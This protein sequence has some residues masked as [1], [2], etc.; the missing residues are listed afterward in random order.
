MSHGYRAV[1]RHHPRVKRRAAHYQHALI[2]RHARGLPPHLLPGITG[3]TKRPTR[4]RMALLAGT[5][6]F[7]ITLIVGVIGTVVSSVAAVGGTLHAYREV[8]EGLPNAAAIATDAYE[9]AEIYDRN[10]VL[11]QQVSHPDQGWRTFVALDQV[12]EVAIDAT[13][14]AED[15]TFWSHYGIEPLAILRGALIIAGGEGTSGGST[16]TQQL[17]RGLYPER[18]G[19]DISLTRKFKEILGAVAIDKEY[20]KQ[21]I[22]SMYL[23]LIYYGQRS[24]G[25]E[26]AAQTYFAKSAKELNLAEASMLA[27][28]PQ[29]PSFYDPTVRYDE[30]KVRQR[31]VLD[32]MVKYRYITRAEAEEA[33]AVLLHPQRRNTAIQHAPHFTN[34]VKSYLA[35]TYGEDALYRGGLRIYTT[36]DVELQDRAQRLVSEHVAAMAPYNAHNGAMVV[37]VPWSGEIL[38]MVGSANFDDPLIDGQVNVALAERQPG[39]SIKPITYAAAFEL[40]WNPN[41]VIVDERVRIPTPGAPDPFYEPQNYTS[42]FYGRMTV[43]TALSNSLNIPAVK[44]MQRVGVDRF[45]DLAERMGIKDGLKDRQNYGLALTLGGGEVQLLELTNVYG[46]FANNGRYVPGTPILRIED[47]QGNVIYELDRERVYDEAEQALDADYAYMISSILSDNEARGMIFGRGNLFEQTSEQI[48]RPTTA[49]S[50]TTNDFKDNWTMGYTT[51]AVVGVW[52]GNSDGSPLAQIDGIQGA[53]P[54]WSRMLFELHQNPRFAELLLG[55]NGRPLPEEFQRP[56]GLR[57]AELFCGERGQPSCNTGRGSD[58]N[59]GPGQ[60]GPPENSFDDE[61]E[62]QRIQPVGG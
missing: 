50:G 24:F 37:M 55:P 23:N 44:A 35:E 57:D 40:G 5:L 29:A 60:G 4:W 18:I 41:T 15:A 52:V 54:I 33:F 46:T 3:R 53:G 26:A 14:A 9:S 16:I 47:G 58:S 42:Q 39:S 19:Y 28:L 45:L 43:R 1:G 49:K 2:A 36:V 25:I 6:L 38:A 59:R 56:A 12:S 7:L 32:Q 11:L 27:G 20:S 17:T 61:P 34:Y 10:G 31:Y 62:E 30:A 48:G 13:I 51:D 21:D 8:N 22:L